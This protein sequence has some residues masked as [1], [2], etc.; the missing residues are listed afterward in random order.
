MFSLSLLEKVIINDGDTIVTDVV[1]PC[2]RPAVMGVRRS[3]HMGDG[4]APAWKKRP[5]NRVKKTAKRPL[6]EIFFIILQGGGV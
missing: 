4:Q 1:A 2:T 3:F 5:P 6:T